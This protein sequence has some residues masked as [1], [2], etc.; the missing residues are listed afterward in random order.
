MG[1][2]ITGSFIDGFENEQSNFYV[3]ISNYKID[4]HSGT[5]NATIGHFTSKEEAED[6]S[7]TYQE[8]HA[9]IDNSSMYGWPYYIGEEQVPIPLSFPLT[10][11]ETVN[12]LQYSSSYEDRLID[13][14]DFDE[15][16]NEIIVKRTQ[17]IEIITSASVDVE[18][19]RINLDLITGS[20]YE[21]VYHQVK[22]Y[23][24]SKY[25]ISNVNNN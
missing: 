1:L 5:V 17:P 15:D 18:K 10:Q 4:K 14:I 3:R 11:S 23:Y 9:L 6:F 12:I 20:V 25:G 21:Y 7:P 2:Q 13:F 19:S 8:D 16:G 24:I 22:E